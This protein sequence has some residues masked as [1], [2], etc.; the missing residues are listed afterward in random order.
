M[1]VQKE[2]KSTFLT[3]FEHQE[4]EA[5]SL[6]CVATGLSVCGKWAALHCSRWSCSNT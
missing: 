1:G 4:K 5:R 3:A 6:P 2:Q